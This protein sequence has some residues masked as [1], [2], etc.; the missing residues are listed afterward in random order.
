M[1]LEVHTDLAQREEE[2]KQAAE[3]LSEEL[4]RLQ[5]EVEQERGE[6]ERA[7]VQLERE[8]KRRQ[9]VEGRSAEASRLRGRVE[10]LED[11]VSELNGQIQEERDAAQHHTVEWQQEK[12][13]LCRLMEEER[14]D[15]HKQ[16]AE[17]QLQRWEVLT[18]S[19]SIMVSSCAR[20]LCVLHYLIA[21]CRS[22]T[23]STC[24]AE[25]EHWR[26][27]YEELYAK[28]KPFQVSKDYI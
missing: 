20:S 21:Y 23:P 1:L 3:T 13:Q 7:Q 17:A 28:V 9:S 15:Y 24:N 18:R 4:R 5:A 11:K 10:E 6:R 16:L 8:Q 22:F 25:T 27:M 12:R 19:K 2:L 14:Q 26:N